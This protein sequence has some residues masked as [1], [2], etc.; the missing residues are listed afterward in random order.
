MVTD[1]SKIYARKYHIIP[2]GFDEDDI[3]NIEV[4]KNQKI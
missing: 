4:T 3:R 1:F 2:N